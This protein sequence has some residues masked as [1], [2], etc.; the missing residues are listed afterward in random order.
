[1]KLELSN[2][3]EEKSRYK[4]V[5]TDSFKDLPEPY[6]IKYAYEVSGECCISVPDPDQPGKFNDKVLSFG[7]NGIRIIRRFRT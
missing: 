7:P 5:L 4:I 6:E 3:F 2:S 1:M